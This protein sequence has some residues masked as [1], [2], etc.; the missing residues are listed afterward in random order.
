MYR[1]EKC[2][3][4]DSLFYYYGCDMG[5]HQIATNVSDQIHSIISCLYHLTEEES[6]CRPITEVA[7]SFHVLI[8]YSH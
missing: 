6:F 5:A 8:G 4:C 7:I 2:H 1:W 3:F